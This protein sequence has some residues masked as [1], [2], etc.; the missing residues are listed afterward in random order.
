[1]Q[2]SAKL[3][4]QKDDFESERAC[5]GNHQEER[6]RRG[7]CTETYH[8]QVMEQGNEDGEE[9]T[10]GDDSWHVGKLKFRKHVD[11]EY[12][13]R[14]REDERVEK[15]QQGQPSRSQSAAGPGSKEL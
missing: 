11:D 4:S 12:R 2:F 8:G 7:P 10:D 5:V 14:S 15:R 9:A 1:M 6:H 13:L 3:K